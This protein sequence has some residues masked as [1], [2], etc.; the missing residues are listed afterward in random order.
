[1][2]L[3]E[4]SKCVSVWHDDSFS[5]AKIAEISTFVPI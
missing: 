5:E 4:R 2:G 1:M 3:C